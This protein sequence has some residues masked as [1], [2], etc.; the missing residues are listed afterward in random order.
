MTNDILEVLNSAK[1]I[2]FTR[3]KS[4]INTCN[5]L[6]RKENKLSD[7]SRT[8]IDKILKRPTQVHLEPNSLSVAM[9]NI[10]NLSQN[11]PRACNTNLNENKRAFRVAFKAVR[12]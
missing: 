4:F 12:Y 10:P 6:F 2:S 9:H 5:F 11:L 1:F 3:E 8:V 7:D